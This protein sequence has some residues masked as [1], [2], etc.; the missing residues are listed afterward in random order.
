[1]TEADVETMV[2]RSREGYPGEKRRVISVNGPH[3]IARD[4]NAFVRV[5]DSTP[6]SAT[7]TASTSSPDEPGRSIPSA[8]EDSNRAPEFGLLSRLQDAA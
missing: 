8:I 6:P 7:S 2:Q 3:F 5:V 1:M 4:L